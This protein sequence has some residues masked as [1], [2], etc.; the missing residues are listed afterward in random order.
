MSLPWGQKLFEMFLHRR[1]V[2]SVLFIYLFYHL[3]MSI[4]THGYLF[5]VCVI[6]KY[7]F[8][9]YSNCSSSD[10]WELFQLT[11]ETL[12]STF[13][14][15]KCLFIQWFGFIYIYFFF[16]YFLA[17]E[18][19]PSLSYIFPVPVLELAI[20]PRSLVSS[21]GLMVLQT[22]LVY[23]VCSLLLGWHFF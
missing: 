5:I 18:N 20:S 9:S 22:K 6:N 15:M 12:W 16:P 10:H 2:S 21:A 1:T 19:G 7:F 13:I 4:Q 11:P 14:I 3:F 23:Q 8:I 17:L